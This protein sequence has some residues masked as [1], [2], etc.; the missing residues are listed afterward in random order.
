MAIEDACSI[1]QLLP[2]GTSAS[3]VP[4]RLKLYERVRH[5]RATW[6]QEQTRINAMDEDKRPASKIRSEMNM[7]RARTN[8]MQQ[9]KV[10]SLCWSTAT[11]MMSG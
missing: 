3:D 4:G 5:E 6:V 1:A 2:E 9:R 7:E 11:A 10:D 8:T